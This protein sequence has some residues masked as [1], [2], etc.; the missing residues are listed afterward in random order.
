MNK[1]T[2]TV[3][4]KICEKC[5]GT[6]SL[7]VGNLRELHNEDIE[8]CPYCFNDGSFIMKTTIEFFKKTEENDCALIPKA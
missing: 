8:G 2:T 4:I 7:R 6:G 5:D 1:T 3:R